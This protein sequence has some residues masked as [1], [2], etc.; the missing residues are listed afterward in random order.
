M[1]RLML[2]ISVYGFKRVGSSGGKRV[3]IAVNIQYCLL[4]TH[5]SGKIEIIFNRSNPVN[6]LGT[7]A[8]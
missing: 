7:F 6:P 5:K 2:E 1:L 3:N 4:K 8:L